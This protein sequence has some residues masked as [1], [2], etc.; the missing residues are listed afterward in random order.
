[1]SKFL[2]EVVAYFVTACLLLTVGSCTVGIV[3]SVVREVLR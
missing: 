2:G 1:M 3:V